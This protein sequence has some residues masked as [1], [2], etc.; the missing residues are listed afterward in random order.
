MA[1]IE[2]RGDRYFSKAR[3]GN[4]SMSGLIGANFLIVLVQSNPAPSRAFLAVGLAV[5]LGFA[6]RTAYSFVILFGE[7]VLTVR[8]LYRT[9]SF[10]YRYLASVE[11]VAP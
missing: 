3:V 5:C 8:G 10:A 7:D 2:K 9:R 6:V 4:A 1:L 11:A